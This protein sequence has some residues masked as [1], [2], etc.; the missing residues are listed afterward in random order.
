[1]TILIF[2]IQSMQNELAISKSDEKM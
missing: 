2:L 1:M